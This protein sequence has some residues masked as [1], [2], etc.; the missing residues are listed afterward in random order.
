MKKLREEVLV[1]I[2]LEYK[3]TVYVRGIEYTVGEDDDSIEWHEVME[4]G[5]CN[6]VK[7]I[8]LYKELEKTY[9]R[10]FINEE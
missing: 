7:D 10:K 3:G 5:N 2:Y 9:I 1:E 8:D 4:D 6:L